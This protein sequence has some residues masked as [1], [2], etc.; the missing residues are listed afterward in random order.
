MAKS[1]SFRKTK[2]VATIGPASWDKEKLGEL[3]RGGMNIARLNFSHGELERHSE[4]VRNIRE[5]AMELGA[6]VGILQDLQGPKIRLNNFKGERV[7]NKGDK[8][9]VTSSGHESGEKLVVDFASLHEFVS[10]GQSVFIDDGIMEL[11]V[12][13]VVGVDLHCVVVHG[14]VARP[15]KGVNLPDSKIPIASMTE[16]DLEDLR[17]GIPLE[18]DY[19]ALSFVR[20]VKDIVD[21]KEL[22]NKLGSKARVVAKIEKKEAIENIEAIVEASDAIMIARGDLAVE[23]GQVHLPAV[24]KKITKLCNQKGKP[25]IT[26][27]QMLDSMQ[28]NSRPT[29]AEITDVANAVLDGSD[30]LMLSGESAFGNYPVRSVETMHEII[31]E[32]EKQPGIYYKFKNRKK[33]QFTV[34]ESI[35]ISTVLCSKQL[36]AK[37]IVCMSTTGR[38]AQ[39]IS[40]YRPKAKLI[41]VTYK[42]EA[43]NRLELC[44]GVQTLRINKFDNTEDAFAQIES[45][46]KEYKIVA[47][48][49]HVVLT[50]GLPVQQGQKTN[51][52]RVFTIGS[53]GAVKDNKSSK[54]PV[55]FLSKT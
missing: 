54:K 51:S 49:D 31:C 17:N 35:A 32:V 16:K 25:V 15:R 43:L 37:T 38:T 5:V 9:I 14:G 47:P 24:Q 3:I 34:P 46:L 52:V 53:D 2:I 1:L 12:K 30:A 4:T 39:M 21:L 44:W 19:V 22:L 6:P 36:A 8:V 33:D 10:P 18:F 26:A 48:G 42:D 40:K 41:A 45:L 29:R 13:K 11:Q 28:E 50:L 7:L 55:R 23:I 27:T 20:A